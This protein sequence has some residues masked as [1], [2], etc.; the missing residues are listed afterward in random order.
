[1]KKMIL[2]TCCGN[3]M[4]WFDHQNKSITQTNDKHIQTTSNEEPTKFLEEHCNNLKLNTKNDFLNESFKAMKAE[5]ERLQKGL[6]EI[7]KFADSKY[8][9]R[10]LAPSCSEFFYKSNGMQTKR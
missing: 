8:E 9:K 7:A 4:F 1:M 6:Q 2:D 3:R 5:N 10:I